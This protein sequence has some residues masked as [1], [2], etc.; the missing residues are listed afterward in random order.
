MGNLQVVYIGK[1]VPS[2]KPPNAFGGPPL[3][4]SSAAAPLG[5]TGSAAAELRVHS[6][7]GR[8]AQKEA[9]KKYNTK[10]QT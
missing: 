4:P 7:G 1:E 5:Q 2:A 6:S 3:N 8:E 9:N 10:R